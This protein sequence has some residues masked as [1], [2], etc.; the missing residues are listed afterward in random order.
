MALRCV[1]REKIDGPRR[2]PER[3]VHEGV[4]PW[5]DEK[6]ENESRIGLIRRFG[7]SDFLNDILSLLVNF[8]E[9]IFCGLLRA[10]LGE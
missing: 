3:Y 8:V 2:D 1:A 6:R 7:C 10:S 4:G 5:I 9:R